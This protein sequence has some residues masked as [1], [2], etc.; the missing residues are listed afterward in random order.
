[1]LQIKSQQNFWAGVLFLSVGAGQTWLALRYNVGTASQMGPGF[2]PALLGGLLMVLG[3]L[4][5]AGSLV[6]RGPRIEPVYWRPVVCIVGSLLVFALLI[7]KAGLALTAALVVLVAGSGYRQ[8]I[9]WAWLVVL[10][11]GMAALAVGIF[12]HGLKQPIP[13]WWSWG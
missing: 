1:M 8:R 7:E 9:G 12:I 5:A 6:I 3:L 4:I 13:A 10:A 2:M 11:L